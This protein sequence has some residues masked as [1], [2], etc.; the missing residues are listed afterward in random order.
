MLLRLLDEVTKGLREKL[1]NLG[2]HVIEIESKKEKTTGI[3][4]RDLLE[5]GIDDQSP[6]K[7]V[8]KSLTPKLEAEYDE[9]YLIPL[10]MLLEERK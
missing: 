10:E 3:Y 6:H 1:L 2:F 8:T 9:E 5:K 7:T 4:S